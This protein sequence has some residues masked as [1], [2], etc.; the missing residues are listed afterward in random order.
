MGELIAERLRQPD[1]SAGFILDG[2]P[3]TVAQVGILDGVLE[4]LSVDLDGAYLLVAPEAEIV[5]RLSG[6]RICPGCG[7]VYHVDNRPPRSAGV[8]DKCGSALVQRPDDTEEV[9]LD[10]LK[11]FRN[12]TLPIAEIYRERGLL[13]EVD[14]DGDPATVFDRLRAAVEQA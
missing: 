12:Q 11:V 7:E 6:R 1:A 9:I 5:S 3:R 10:R 14:G 4:K 2:F 8:C 13:R